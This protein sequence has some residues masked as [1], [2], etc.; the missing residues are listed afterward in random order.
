MISKR[1]T[2]PISEK[3]SVSAILSIP[4]S[5]ESETVVIVAHGAGNDMNHPFLVSFCENLAKAGY[6]AAR[7]NFPYKEH[8]RKGPDR[9]EILELTWRQVFHFV[10]DKSRHSLRN[11]FIAGKSM[12]G[13]VASQ[14]LADGSLTCDGIIFLGYPLNP[15]GSKEKLRDEH[16]YLIKIP[17]LFFAGTRDSLCDLDLLK[18][19]IS[20]LEPQTELEV[21]E[22]A[23][24]SFNV[25]KSS[26]L[27]IQQVY[28]KIAERSIEWIRGTSLDEG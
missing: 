19:V 22:G 26:S 4:D 2:I 6:V 8:G 27:T 5:F 11:I 21:I 18:M 25:P 23:D 10:K 7:F 20:R 12:G 17:I 16:L 1:V 15:A 24:H 28:A 9:Q 13:R 14:M 3:E